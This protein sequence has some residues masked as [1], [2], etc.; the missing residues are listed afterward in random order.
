MARGSSKTP[1]R[2]RSALDRGDLVVEALVL[3][4]GGLLVNDDVG[5]GKGLADARPRPRG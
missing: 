2:P 3:E 4:A 1:S 5:L